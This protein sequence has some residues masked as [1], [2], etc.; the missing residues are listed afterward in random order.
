MPSTQETSSEGLAPKHPY[1][2]PHLK[3]PCSKIICDRETGQRLVQTA[4][5]TAEEAAQ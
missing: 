5:E 3:R 1:T 2:I 4:Q